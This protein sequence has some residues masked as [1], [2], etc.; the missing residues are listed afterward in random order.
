LHVNTAEM[1]LELNGVGGGFTLRHRRSGQR[2]LVCEQP[3]LLQPEFAAGPDPVTCPR[4]E[5]VAEDALCWH[6]ESAGLADFRVVA[7][8]T[9]ESI[10]LSCQFTPRKAQRLARLQLFPA[11]TWINMYRLINFRNRHFTEQTGPELL[12]DGP[13]CETDTYS[14]DWQFA[15]HPTALVFQKL[16]LHLFCGLLEPDL[17]YGMYFKAQALRVAH[18]Y[19]DY[20]ETAHGLRLR[21][22]EPFVSPTLR[23]FLMETD[24]PE[25]VYAQ[26][27]AQLVAEGRLSDPRRK[28]RYPWHT[29][30]LYCTW[31]DQVYASQ[32]H[33]EPELKDQAA[34]PPEQAS[35][36][37][38]ADFVRRAVA[39]IRQERLPFRT[40]LIDEGWQVARGDWRP[41]PERFPD[42]RGLVDELHAQGFKVVVWWNWSELL[43]SVAVP[44]EQLMNGG[45]VNR[46]GY[47]MR[48]YSKPCTQAYL[49]DLFRTL[50]SPAPDGYDLDGIKTDFQADKVHP[51]M[52][53]TDP[54]WRGEENYFRRLYA[55][56][57]QEMRRHKPD[58]VHIGCSGNYYLAEY[59]DINRTYD[60]HTSNYREHAA[61]A[62]MLLA[63]APGVPVAYDIHNFTEQLEEYCASARELGASV[64]IGNV[65]YV[66]SDKGSPPVPAEP[67]Y[68]ERLRALL[69]QSGP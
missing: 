8:S 38:S 62:R 21:A 51:D 66:R 32:A 35:T 33:V 17:S 31:I 39:V 25:A 29:E 13:G 10:D 26:F 34:A 24:E 53:P 43:D 30:N 11:A 4:A 50:F 19:L 45:R 65:L 48:D 64:Q 41:H 37:L 47:R 1:S 56:F 59:I 67:G 16:A 22:G 58:A 52:S 7:R 55:F 5:Q 63:T 42:M 9:A 27:G 23:L 69:A 57:Y 44:S 20:G 28:V 18:W 40:I 68:Y 54:E 2:L 15:P 12:L 3:L 36:L 14:G 61:R 60:V 49:R 6:Y 46:Y